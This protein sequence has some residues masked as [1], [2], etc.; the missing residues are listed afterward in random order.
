M[1]YVCTDTCNSPILSKYNTTISQE[2][3]SETLVDKSLPHTASQTS[4]STD[5]PLST[6]RDSLLADRENQV[7]TQL[8]SSIMS[9]YGQDSTLSGVR[10]SALARAGAPIITTVSHLN[11]SQN[12][13]L[14]NFF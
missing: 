1:L 12:L 4:I 10:S 13:Y 6:R 5:L 7:D 2:R 8:P 9:L 3:Q 14:C 11:H